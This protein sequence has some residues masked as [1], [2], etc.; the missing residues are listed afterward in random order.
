MKTL[1]RNRPGFT[2]IEVIVAMAIIMIGIGFAVPAFQSIGRG[3]ALSAAGNTVATL[4]ASARQN[5][6]SRNVLTAMIVLTGTGTEADCRTV[7]LY[8]YGTGGYWQ[9]I[10]KWE[11]LPV[12]IV[13][14]GQDWVNCSFMENSPDL[15]RLLDGSGESAVRYHGVPVPPT[16]FATRIFVPSGALS[17]PD[18][19]AQL[20]LVEGFVDGNSIRYTHRSTSGPGPANYF[21]LAIVGTTGATKISRP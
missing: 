10:G 13:I 5:S 3:T 15:P 12:G 20:R 21:D 11:T 1:L 7:G 6:T 4:A 19:P 17:N 16:A 2:L 8:E 18:K 14:D 9:Q